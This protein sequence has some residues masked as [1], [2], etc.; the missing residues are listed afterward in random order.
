AAFGEGDGPERVLALCEAGLLYP[1]LLAVPAGPPRLRSFQQWLGQGGATGFSFF[2]HPNVLARALTTDLG[3]PV[4]AADVSPTGGVH[5]ADGLEWP[6]R[7]AALW[8]Q[9]APTPLRRT[10]TGDFFKRD[11]DRLRADS[12]LNAPPAD[13]LA[14]LPDTGLLA[15]AL[16]GAEG[17][18]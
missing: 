5:E 8:Q 14:D 18:L 16:A 3:L 9:L 13:N 6:L 2:A 12:L 7:L 4:L 1:D 11:L 15:I 10:Q 17:I